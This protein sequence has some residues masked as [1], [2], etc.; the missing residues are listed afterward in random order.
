VSSGA[1]A[2]AI[3]PI[4]QRKRVVFFDVE[5]GSRFERIAALLRALGLPAGQHTSVFAVGNWRVVG[6]ETAQLL[7][8]AGAVLVHSAPQ[9]GVKDWSDLRIAVDAGR[10]LATAYPADLLEI[11]SDDQAFDAVG[12][13]A[14]SLGVVFRRVSARWRQDRPERSSVRRPSRKRTGESER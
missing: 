1:T 10:W 14:A 12:D 4:F 13:V 3:A 6:L 9:S 5:N 11:V 7:S 2:P 8:R